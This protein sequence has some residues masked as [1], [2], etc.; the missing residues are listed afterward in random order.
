MGDLRSRVLYQVEQHEKSLVDAWERLARKTSPTTE[1]AQKLFDTWKEQHPG[2]NFTPA[3]FHEKGESK[4]KKPDKAKGDSDKADKTKGDKADSVRGK[5]LAERQRKKELANDLAQ[6]GMDATE[7]DLSPQHREEIEGYNIEVVGADAAQ[8]VEVA[9][10]IKEGIEKSADICKMSPSVCEGNMGLTRDNMPQ[11][12]GGS[13][14]KEM[15]TSD[16]DRIKDATFSDPKTKK[17]VPF[18][19]LPEKE[20]AK[21]KGKWAADRAKGT[22]MVQAGADP[23]ESRT[24]MQQMIDFLGKNGTATLDESIPVGELKATQKEIQAQKAFGMADSHLKGKFKSIGDSVVISRDGHIL[25]GHHRWAA[26]LTIDPSRK[27]KVKV[28][29]MDMA[30]LL[31]EAQAVPGVYRADIKGD[32]LGESDQKDYKAKSKSKFGQKE[33]KPVKKKATVQQAVLK[34]AKENPGFRKALIAE[35]Q[36]TAAPKMVGVGRYTRGAKPELLATIVSCTKY[37]SAAKKMLP[38]IEIMAKPAGAKQSWMRQFANKAR[39]LL[40]REIAKQKYGT[41]QEE[42]CVGVAEIGAYSTQES[43]SDDSYLIVRSDEP[44]LAK[45]IMGV[46]QQVRPIS[47]G[48][49]PGSSYSGRGAE[50]TSDP[51]VWLYNWSSYGIGD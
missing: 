21:F 45:I 27:M 42:T 19:K 51:G 43:W 32:P 40:D 49:V 6:Y 46:L 22:A 34:L 25:D 35:L 11:I 24:V 20:Q 41:P 10:K 47:G 12:E 9:R 39:P 8:A 36:K 29:D 1:G 28:I 37:D 5:L 30:D 16:E 38:S 14:V 23:E 44:R 13:S 48:G 31:E 4:D 33:D 50:K 15:L 3:D 7:K 26:L 17:E 2:T 18:D